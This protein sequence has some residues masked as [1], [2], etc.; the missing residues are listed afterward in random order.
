MEERLLKIGELAAAFGVTPR[1]IRYYEELGLIEAANR[2][3]GLHRR[4]PPVTFIQLK[5]IAELKDLG[6]S[7]GQIRDFFALARE[8]ASGESCRQLMLALYA[9]QIE[10]ERAAI[11]AAEARIADIESRMSALAAKPHFFSCPGEECAQ[12]TFD[13]ICTERSSS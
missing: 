3:E 11:R 6:L 4:Y 12:C 8:D 13:G 7:L 9:R 5:R 2:T 1:T 10:E